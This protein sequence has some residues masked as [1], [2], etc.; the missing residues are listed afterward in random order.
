MDEVSDERTQRLVADKCSGVDL[1]IAAT[2]FGALSHVVRLTALLQLVEREW[3]VSELAAHL[4]ISQSSLS[5][6][7]GK[8]RDC[9]VVRSRKMRQTVFYC[10]DDVLVKKLLVEAGL[11]GARDP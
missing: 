6:H 11:V 8:L 2:L 10:C 9:K 4:Q 3:S 1:E 5:Q 7:L